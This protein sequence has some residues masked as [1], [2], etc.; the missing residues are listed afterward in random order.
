MQHILPEVRPFVNS[1]P[2]ETYVVQTGGSA[3]SREINTTDNSRVEV[4]G[5]P[6]HTHNATA[7]ASI[8]ADFRE[9][10]GAAV[11]MSAEQ[12]GVTLAAAHIT[13]SNTIADEVATFDR[14][15]EKG[16]GTIKLLPEN[17]HHEINEPTRAI[18]EVRTIVTSKQQ[19]E[20]LTYIEERGGWVNPDGGARIVSDFPAVYV[21]LI[22]AAGPITAV[23]AAPVDRQTGGHIHS[24]GVTESGG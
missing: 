17:C 3:R 15:L 18:A 23:G 1:M 14:A 12:G 8:S 2:E 10:R 6:G 13:D 19:L 5:V 20:S 9:L 7:I 24:S 22:G 11:V 4:S 21:D 16:I